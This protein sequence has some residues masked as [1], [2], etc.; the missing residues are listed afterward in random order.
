MSH[1]SNFRWTLFLSKLFWFF[2]VFRVKYCFPTSLVILYT[3]SAIYITFLRKMFQEL[4]IQ[5]CHNCAPNFQHLLM[6][7]CTSWHK[8]IS[9]FYTK[10]NM[11]IKTQNDLHEQQ[12]SSCFR[13]KCM[14]ELL[15][16][17]MVETNQWQSLMIVELL[18][19]A[20]GVGWPCAKLFYLVL[21]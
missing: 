6:F 17:L 9:D 5:S 11:Q 4:R 19:Q 14:F 3:F 13:Y 8:I 12:K 18:Y 7:F 10:H 16:T 2:R 1:N 20:N 15:I 21:R